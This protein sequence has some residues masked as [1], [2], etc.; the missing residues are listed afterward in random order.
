M[1]VVAIILDAFDYRHLAL[2]KGLPG[3]KG[4]RGFTIHHHA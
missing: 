2:W 4:V 3:I 1:I